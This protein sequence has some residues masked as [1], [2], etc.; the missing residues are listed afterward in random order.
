MQLLLELLIKAAIILTIIPK[1]QLSIFS[2]R[3]LLKK[4][5]RLKCWR[6]IVKCIVTSSIILAGPIAK[7][8]IC[9]DITVLASVISTA[10]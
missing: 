10:A 8:H 3:T 6:V 1:L 9:T 4:K 7:P 2:E 5:T